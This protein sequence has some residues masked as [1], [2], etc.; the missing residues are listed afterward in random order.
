MEIVG[1]FLFVSFI[2]AVVA[3]LTGIYVLYKMDLA[4][5]KKEWDEIRNKRT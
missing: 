3:G 1:W 4:E 5:A 2:V